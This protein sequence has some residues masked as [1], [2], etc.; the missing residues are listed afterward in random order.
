MAER[1]VLGTKGTAVEES[2][3]QQL[4]SSLRGDLL[5]PGDSGYEDARKIWNGMIDKHPALIARCSGTADV[6]AAINF[7]RDNDLLVAVRGGGHNVA[8]KAVCDGG[9][10]IDLSPMKGIRVDPARRV[11]RAQ[12]GLTWGEFD[13]ETQAFGLALTGGTQST[14]GIAGFTLGGGF[15][16]LAREYGLTCDNL[17]SAD[18]VTADGRF[19]TAS[20]TENADLFWGIRGGGGNFGI[21]TSFEFKLYPVGPVLGGMVLYPL[22]Q[23]KSVLRFYRDYIATAPEELSTLV[24]FMT[25]PQAPPLPEHIRGT[26]VI[27]IVACYA[28]PIAAG[29]RILQPIRKFGPPAA[30]LIG[31]MPYT[32]LQKMLDAGNPPGRQ[33]YWK[34][35]Y[36]KGLDDDAIETVVAYVAR[37]ES[38]MSK[39]LFAQLG[40]AISQVAEDE[41]A[42]THRK[43]PFVVDIVAQWPDPKE[44]DRNI[45]WARDFWTAMRP[46]SAGGVYVNFLSDEGEERVKDAY[47]P[48]A[49]ARLVALKNK[50]DPT[51]FF[52]LNQNIKPTV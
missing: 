12:P 22:A 33:N 17:L 20:P 27:A 7:A 38:P 8:G 49:Y 35:E 19:L 4:K 41:T 36:I 28:G 16:W 26:S 21:V 29:E 48:K 39:V 32:S 46:F 23:A 10:V 5:R 45:A 13:H 2:A 40:G 25:A 42:Y 15:G 9:I 6:I 14:T 31:E 3:V 24:V 37:Q 30:D 50:Y 47:T 34:A 18:V 52:R 43:A 44:S 51:N 11:A 1:T